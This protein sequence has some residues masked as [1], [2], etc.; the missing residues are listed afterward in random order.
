[1]AKMSLKNPPVRGLPSIACLL[2]GTLQREDPAHPWP[3][4]LVPARAQRGEGLRGVTLAVG[5]SGWVGEE[6]E[7]SCPRGA[8]SCVQHE[9][10][11][12][13]GRFLQPGS[14]HEC[15]LQR[16]GNEEDD[17]DQGQ[18]MR[19]GRGNSEETCA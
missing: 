7:P 4:L 9:E 2:Q 11:D 12:K 6:L 3:R 13:K 14:I 10:R 19:S 17:Q 1:M 15:A 16:R 8:A 18:L 5:C